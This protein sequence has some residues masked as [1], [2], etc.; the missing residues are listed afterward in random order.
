MY[1]LENESFLLVFV[2]L[3]KHFQGLSH[4]ENLIH[5]PLFNINTIYNDFNIKII[6]LD[7]KNQVIEN[8]CVNYKNIFSIIMKQL[9]KIHQNFLKFY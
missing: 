9:S 7:I 8:I 4:M 6:N 5:R 2:L 3:I 1:K